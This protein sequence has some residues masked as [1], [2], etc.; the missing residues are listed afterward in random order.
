MNLR[1]TGLG[2]RAEGMGRQKPVQNFPDVEISWANSRISY[3]ISYHYSRVSEEQADQSR[4][5]DNKRL[6]AT[7][8]NLYFVL[9]IMESH[10]KILRRVVM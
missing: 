8:K 3:K 4:R 10:C 5:S 2:A 6:K 7:G 9:N 1:E